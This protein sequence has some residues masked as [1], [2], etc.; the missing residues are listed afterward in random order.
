MGFAL[1]DLNK[2]LSTHLKVCHGFLLSLSLLSVW[3]SIIEFS[4]WPGQVSH[5]ADKV[6]DLGATDPAAALNESGLHA[7]GGEIMHYNHAHKHPCDSFLPYEPV[8]LW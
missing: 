7:V 6:K 2:E 4:C 8:R 1:H 3:R 5:L